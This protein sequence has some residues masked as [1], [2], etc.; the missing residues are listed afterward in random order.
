VRDVTESKSRHFF[1]V[2][3][4][5][6]PSIVAMATPQKAAKIGQLIQSLLSNPLTSTLGQVPF[7]VPV[8]GLFAGNAT[9]VVFLLHS[10]T[11]LSEYPRLKYQP[12]KAGL[13]GT[14][15]PFRH[16]KKYAEILR[17]AWP[18]A[19]LLMVEEV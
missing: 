17:T 9:E 14:I 10:A 19:S 18:P 12:A 7:R 3:N 1:G 2:A 15:L 11:P 6:L 5:I 8:K 4:G 13:A 16:L